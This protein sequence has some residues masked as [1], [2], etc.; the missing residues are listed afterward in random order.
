MTFLSKLGKVMSVVGKV[1]VVAG[2]FAPG[3]VAMTPTKKDDEIWGKVSPSLANI[4]SI[5]A[6][7]EAMSAALVEP[8]PGAQKLQMATPIVAQIILNDLVAG[9]KIQDAALFRT[10][11]ERITGGIADVLN[12]IKEDEVKTT[13]VSE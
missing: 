3:L 11:C 9:K 1:I 10:G 5:V 12:S 7:V 2:G 4:A 13:T 6:A 8:I